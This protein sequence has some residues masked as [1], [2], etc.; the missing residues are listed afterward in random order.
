[1]DVPECYRFQ[2]VFAVQGFPE[3]VQQAAK[4][5]RCDRHMQWRAG[6]KYG[7][8]PI[9]AAAAMQRN[10]AQMMF[11]QVLVD[12]KQVGFAVEV[13]TQRLVQWGEGVAG[14]NHH[15]AV[16]LHNCPDGC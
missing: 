16:D 14:N 12:F 9:E 7:H 6:V 11:V 15:R 10:S 4:A 5:I 8:T 3:N 13:S 2:L 1:M